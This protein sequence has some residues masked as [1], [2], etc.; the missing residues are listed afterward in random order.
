MTLARTFCLTAIMMAPS[1]FAQDTDIGSL[2]ADPNVW[3]IC[4]E[5]S[6]VMRIA[7]GT[8]QNGTMTAR[9]WQQI[10]P[11]ACVSETPP[12]GTPRYIYAQSSPVHM[13]RVREWK[14]NVKLCASDDDFTADATRSCPLQDLETRLY[15]Q[16]NP[17]ER[18]TTFIEPD[19]F[20]EN[21]DTAGLQRLL[22]DNGYKVSRVDGLPGRRTSRNVSE[23]LKEN[24][25]PIA[26]SIGE[27]F[28][29]LIEG[30]RKRQDSIGLKVC[31]TSS[32]RIWTA[33]AY[34][35]QADWHSRGWWPIEAGDCARPVS[36]SLIDT[37]THLFAQ[38]EPPNTDDGAP[39]PDRRIRTVAATPQQF[40]IAEG[41][42]SALGNEYCEDR[43]YEAVSFRP[44]PVELEGVSITLTDADFTTPNATG[45]RR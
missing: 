30:A 15:L 1:A 37:D 45:L 20:G 2:N 35:D 36:D 38:Q 33:V 21:A 13:G 29:A 6:Y 44:L 40:C 7:V 16:V 17:T 27:K 24:D 23:F 31:N 42:F 14:G 34:R 19:N 41:V 10:R 26:I 32:R 3:N 9:G 39:A 18:N 28:D 8:M 5:T 22:R 11:G 12:P 43:G 25:L 4:N